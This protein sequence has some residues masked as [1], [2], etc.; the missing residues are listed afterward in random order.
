ML[1]VFH[2]KNHNFVKV[3]IEAFAI[4]QAKIFTVLLIKYLYGFNKSRSLLF[5]KHKLKSLCFKQK[6]LHFY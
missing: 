2:F 4:L 3:I 1:N 6:S 5:T